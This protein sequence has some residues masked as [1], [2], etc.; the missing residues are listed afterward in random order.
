MIHEFF[1]FL[2][3]FNLIIE[4]DRFLKSHSKF[5]DF[6]RLF[7]I[8]KNYKTIKNPTIEWLLS[9]CKVDNIFK[10]DFLKL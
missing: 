9:F 2:E 10:L 7:L 6:E 5:H 8:L 4:F 1:N 3:L